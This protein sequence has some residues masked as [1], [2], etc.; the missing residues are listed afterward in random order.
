MNETRG[1]KKTNAEPVNKKQ[2]Q[3]R[4][5]QRA[6]QER[7]RLHVERLERR[8]HELEAA[9][10]VLAL[11]NKSANNPAFCV[12][13]LAAI[14]G[15][16]GKK[17][18]DPILAS[19]PIHFV[20]T[21]ITTHG[22][23]LHSFNSAA[24]DVEVPFDSKF[25][26]ALFQIDASANLTT[27]LLAS[28]PSLESNTPTLSAF[29]NEDWLE[30]EPMSNERQQPQPACKSAVEMFGP[31]H[32]EFVRY[33]INSIP[34]LRD[35]GYA[36]TLLD[37]F[38]EQ[39]QFTDKAK[40]QR[41]MV[42]LMQNWVKMIEHCK[43]PAERRIIYEMDEIFHEINRDHMVW[44]FQFPFHVRKRS[45]IFNLSAKPQRYYY[46]LGAKAAEN[47]AKS[48]TTAVLQLTD[49]SESLRKRLNL[50]PSFKDAGP[51]IDELCA[52]YF[53][54][55]D[56]EWSFFRAGT[57]CEQLQDMCTTSDDRAR[58]L[59]SVDSVKFEDWDQLHEALN[60]LILNDS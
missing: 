35:F 42:I 25:T 23:A 7:K 30:Q 40:V 55:S 51:L 2:A 19:N 43:D 60:E 15:E 34:S 32:S 31:V 22:H 44:F 10:A 27:H 45:L 18:L 37:I 59:A 38:E 58:F 47:F 20:N 41:S 33:V 39:A 11:A 5:A 4:A 49:E 3:V 28:E 14:Q 17:D 54:S 48:R 53:H 16:P 46:G 24:M 8:V 12:N 52:V 9:N 56:P 29:N 50:I 6:F 26:P 13:C 21:D 36:N 57:L 1:R